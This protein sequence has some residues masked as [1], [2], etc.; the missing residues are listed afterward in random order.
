MT[1][2]CNFLLFLKKSNSYSIRSKNVSNVVHVFNPPCHAGHFMKHFGPQKWILKQILLHFFY[3]M[4]FFKNY[5]N[6]FSSIFIF[7]IAGELSQS[8]MY[9]RLQ[10]R[11]NPVPESLNSPDLAPPGSASGLGRPPAKDDAIRG[12]N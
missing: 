8:L 12:E 4:H 1:N 9:S 5:H 7:F 3:I 6:F 2:S 11:L 10:S